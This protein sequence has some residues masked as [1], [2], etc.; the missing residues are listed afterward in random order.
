MRTMCLAATEQPSKFF[1]C[2]SVEIDASQRISV[3]ASVV[4]VGN[5]ISESIQTNHRHR[6]PTSRVPTITPMLRT[7][8]GEPLPGSRQW[9]RQRIKRKV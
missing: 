1:F 4:H 7:V 6:M 3:H 9:W 2:V 5:E 8:L